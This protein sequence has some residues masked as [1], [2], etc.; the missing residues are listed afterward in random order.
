M[1][2]KTTVNFSD[3]QLEALRSIMLNY[4]WATPDS[5]NSAR[6]SYYRTQEQQEVAKALSDILDRADIAGLTVEGPVRR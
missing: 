2:A 3:R 1:K 4:G 6:V 5:D